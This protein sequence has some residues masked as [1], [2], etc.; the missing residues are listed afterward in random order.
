MKINDVYCNDKY[1]IVKTRPLHTIMMCI[2]MTNIPLSKPVHCILVVSDYRV[3]LCTRVRCRKFSL[4]VVSFMVPF[5]K[6]KSC[7]L[8]KTNMFIEY[9]MY[10]N[11]K[12]SIVKTRPLYTSCF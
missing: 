3:N 9:S 10:C 4:A 8:Q 1:S 7:F 6:R 11:D 12:Y 5:C 2:V